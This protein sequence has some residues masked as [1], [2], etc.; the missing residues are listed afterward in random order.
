[1]FCVFLQTLPIFPHC[2][3]RHT[4]YPAPRGRHAAS[5][6]EALAAS[7][8][9]L[10][11]P[12]GPEG[13]S[14]QQLPCFLVFSQRE[15]SHYRCSRPKLGGCRAPGGTDGD[16]RELWCRSPGLDCWICAAGRSL[17]PFSSVR[18]D[19]TEPTLGSALHPRPRF[20]LREMR[21]HR[22]RP[23]R[24]SLSSKFYGSDSK[25]T[26]CFLIP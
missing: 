2:Q 21:G 14:S 19:G 5:R 18:G 7:T 8:G 20:P 1:M 11:S 26:V 24:C 10:P 4:S 9:G 12:G 13:S 3:L 25:H 23:S 15:P 6:T 17:G 16:Q 22:A